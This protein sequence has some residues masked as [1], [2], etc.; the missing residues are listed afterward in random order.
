[1]K[2]A[3]YRRR[4]RK[5]KENIERM[6]RTWL[7]A[8]HADSIFIFPLVS[9]WPGISTAERTRSLSFYR[10]FLLPLFPLLGTVRLTIARSRGGPMQNFFARC[11]R[12]LVAERKCDF[13]ADSSAVLFDFRRLFT[14][15]SR[16]PSLIVVSHSALRGMRSRSRAP[17]CEQAETRARMENSARENEILEIFHTLPRMIGTHIRKGSEGRRR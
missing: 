11:N 10:L 12:R 6:F 3:A 17:T 13:P 14:R 9:L 4:G 2:K 7:P 1:M 8:S 5:K 16:F 15:L